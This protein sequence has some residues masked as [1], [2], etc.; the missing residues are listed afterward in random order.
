MAC[1][2]SSSTSGV[3]KSHAHPR[4]VRVQIHLHFKGQLSED[5]AIREFRFP[6][7]KHSG[8]ANLD[9]YVWEKNK[10]SLQSIPYL[11]ISSLL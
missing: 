10:G 9:K 8:E 1:I 11:H 5:F 4:C 2:F 7:V 6:T 3:L